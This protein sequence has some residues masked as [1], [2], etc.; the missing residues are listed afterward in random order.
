MVDEAGSDRVGI[1]ISPE[2]NFNDISDATPQ[3]TYTYLVEQLRGLDLAYLHVALFGATV[4]YHAMLRP[5]FNSAYLIGGGLDRATAEAL[6]AEGRADA[7]VFG[8]SFLA[9]PDLPYGS[10]RAR[11]TQC[12]GQCNVLHASGKGLHRSA[13]IGVI[14]GNYY[15]QR[16]GSRDYRCSDTQQTIG[17]ISTKR[18][19]SFRFIIAPPCPHVRNRTNCAPC[20]DCGCDEIALQALTP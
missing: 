18:K 5:R 15:T 10:V 1:K 13:P 9:N 3:G 6:L 8:S 11:T 17:D 16:K 12:S 7:T 19:V 20:A 4:D 14:A 2:M